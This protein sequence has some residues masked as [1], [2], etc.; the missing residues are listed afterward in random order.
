MALLSTVRWPE[1]HKHTT[2]AATTIH[3]NTKVQRQVA[4]I[5]RL[6]DGNY[7]PGQ[8]VTVGCHLLTRD[9]QALFRGEDD[10][11]NAGD[12]DEHKEYVVPREPLAAWQVTQPRDAERKPSNKKNK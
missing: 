3:H 5:S 6:I 4:Q 8:S 9:L 1:V 11:D 2:T 10:D 7:S 12:A